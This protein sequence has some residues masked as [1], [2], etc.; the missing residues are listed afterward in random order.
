MTAPDLVPCPCRGDGTGCGLMILPEDALKV[1]AALDAGQ[2]EPHHSPEP[3]EPEP[4]LASQ[5]AAGSDAE[6]SSASNQPGN[7]DQPVSYDEN[8][9]RYMAPR[10]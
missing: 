10:W 1:E 7:Y 3:A 8:L 9:R 5:S 4:A 2:P 6:R